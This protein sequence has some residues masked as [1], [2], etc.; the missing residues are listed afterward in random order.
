MNI[1][2]YPVFLPS[3]LSIPL[4]W[5]QAKIFCSFYCSVKKKEKRKRWMK[6]RVRERNSSNASFVF[7]KFHRGSAQ[8][9][10][11][12]SDTFPCTGDMVY[13]MEWYASLLIWCFLFISLKSSFAFV[14]CIS[15][16][17]GNLTKTGLR[18]SVLEGRN[19]R[20]TLNY[21][22]GNVPKYNSLMKN[23][24]LK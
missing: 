21:R 11:I 3:T 18:L 12:P 17:E 22:A 19:R 13:N 4:K 9:C 8:I 2:N 6:K 10:S 14:F 15:M 5:D 24:I 7:M 16:S 20:V 1:E 23:K